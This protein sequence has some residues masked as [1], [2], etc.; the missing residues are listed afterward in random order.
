MGGADRH[1]DEPSVTWSGHESLQPLTRDS[2]CAFRINL[3]LLR[4][5]TRVRAAY[6]ERSHPEVWT[7]EKPKHRGS[8]APPPGAQPISTVL[9]PPCLYL[10]SKHGELPVALLVCDNNLC[11]YLDSYVDVNEMILF[12]FQFYFRI[13]AEHTIL[14]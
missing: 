8:G 14:H 2:S 7:T 4:C 12:Q 1:L 9:P 13:E 3:L 11:Q 10:T 6:P 5:H